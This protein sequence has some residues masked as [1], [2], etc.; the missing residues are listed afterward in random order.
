MSMKSDA[1]R[2]QWEKDWPPDCAFASP[3]DPRWEALGNNT[4]QKLTC[5]NCGEVS[6]NPGQFVR[7]GRWVCTDACRKELADKQS[8]DDL[9]E[10]GGIV[11]AP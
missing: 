11:D 8:Y 3:E 5:A 9:A 7:D 1:D 2:L 6:T 4:A 10:S